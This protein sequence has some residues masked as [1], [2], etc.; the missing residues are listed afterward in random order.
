MFAA[1]A[2]HASIATLSVGP[3]MASSSRDAG[4]LEARATLALDFCCRR[5]RRANCAWL[6]GSA[7]T[8]TVRFAAGRRGSA[9]RREKTPSVIGD[10][11]VR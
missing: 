6:A 1:H 11:A 2:P 9:G 7:P 4:G 5:D 10:C 8:V 3:M